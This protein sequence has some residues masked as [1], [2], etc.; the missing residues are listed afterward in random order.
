MLAS[1]LRNIMQNHLSSPIARRERDAVVVLVDDVR[2]KGLGS[3]SSV[4]SNAIAN[5]LGN[6]DLGTIVDATGSRARLGLGIRDW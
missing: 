6:G 1:D 3:G 5:N 2:G 4:M